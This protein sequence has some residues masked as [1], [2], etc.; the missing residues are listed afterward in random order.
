MVIKQQLEDTEEERAM[1][2]NSD[3]IKFTS[4]NNT[5]EVFMNYL[6]HFVQSIKVI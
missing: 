1:H 5:N 4:G 6:S 2:S 3:T